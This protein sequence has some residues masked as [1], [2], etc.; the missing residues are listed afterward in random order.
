MSLHLLP[1][2]LQ[3]RPYAFDGE[4]CAMV[5]IPDGF[6]VSALQ[7]H[8]VRITS[9]GGKYTWVTRI[10]EVLHVGDGGLGLAALC[11]VES[12]HEVRPYEAPEVAITPE[13]TRPDGLGWWTTLA[14]C[15]VGFLIVLAV[16]IYSA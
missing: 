15:V 2:E 7:G 6:D 12:G 11:R 16:I 8:K 1:D 3:G 14:L 13:E 4:W 5:E 9:L 10:V